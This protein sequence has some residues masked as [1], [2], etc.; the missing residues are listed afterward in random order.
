MNVRT[1]ARSCA[2]LAAAL[3]TSFAAHAQLF[4]AY[5]SSAGSDSNP[6]SLASP[7]R[8]LPAALNAVA[9][10]GEIWMLDSANYNTTTVN[11][12]KSVSI[13]AVPGVVGSVVAT[14]SAEG[15]IVNA[16]GAVVSLSNLVV[17]QLGYGPMGISFV[18]G[19]SLNVNNCQV[20]NATNVGI[21]ASATG[22]ILNVRDT[23]IRNSATGINLVGNVNATI[24][25]VQITGGSFGILG[26][27]GS[28]ATIVESNLSGMGTGVYAFASGGTVRMVVERTAIS[29]T[30]N[31]VY[32]EAVSGGDIADITVRASTVTHAATAAFIVYQAGGSA[33][34]VSD[35]NLVAES[36]VAY[37]FSSGSGTIWTAGNNS[38]R[39]TPIVTQNGSLTSAL[40]NY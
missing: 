24:E 33:S 14:G 36:A 35:G 37:S 26:N 1:A 34:I 11:V 32:S 40:S 30:S 13:L 17:V 10:G 27:P 29:Q 5:V 23:V 22:G 12:T 28:R 38:V 25:R 15:I 31:G 7:C 21:N 39:Y 6:C 2:L 20:S 3:V 4:R 18:Q 19:L 16:P 9:T 8:L